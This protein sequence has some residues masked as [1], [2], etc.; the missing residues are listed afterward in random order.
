LHQLDETLNL[1]TATPGFVWTSILVVDLV[2]G[3]NPTFETL[4][5]TIWIIFIADFLLKLLLAPK[6]GTFLKSNW[7]TVIALVVPT[8]RVFQG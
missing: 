5:G 3:L 4:F 7:L 8:F 1:T 6:N 2:W